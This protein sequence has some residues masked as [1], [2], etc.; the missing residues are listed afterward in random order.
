MVNFTKNVFHGFFCFPGVVVNFVYAILAF[1]FKMVCIVA[2]V[3]AP[4][5]FLLYE[6]RHESPFFI[7]YLIGACI[8]PAFCYAVVFLFIKKF[9]TASRLR[10][11]HL[12][13]PNSF[14]AADD[15][16]YGSNQPFY[17]PQ[18]LVNVELPYTTE[19]LAK[20]GSLD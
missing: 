5:A 13:T 10:S 2:V 15:F 12:D 3:T 14:D 7:F 1:I 9:G 20:Y 6:M 11:N 17:S 4:F 8:W 16:L 19:H 18:A